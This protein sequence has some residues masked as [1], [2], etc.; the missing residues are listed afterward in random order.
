MPNLG[1]E[2]NS[3][4]CATDPQFFTDE[5][6]VFIPAGCP[7][8]G[9]Y[10]PFP[11]ASDLSAWVIMSLLTGTGGPGS[12]E[13]QLQPGT[14]GAQHCRQKWKVTLP[15][16]TGPR[17]SGGADRAPGLGRWQSAAAVRGSGGG[18]NGN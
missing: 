7:R 18:G 5:P 6:A 2:L 9:L 12:L 1:L 16:P 4:L 14:Q 15:G 8:A 13:P 10:T 17:L 11:T 3:R